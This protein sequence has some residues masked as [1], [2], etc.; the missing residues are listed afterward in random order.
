MLNAVKFRE[1]WSESNELDYRGRVRYSDQRWRVRRSK[2]VTS[3]EAIVESRDELVRAICVGHGNCAQ[4]CR[5]SRVQAPVRVLDRNAIGGAKS[6]AGRREQCH[7]AQIRLGSRLADRG[8]FGRD[9]GRE[10]GTQTFALQQ[11]PDLVPARARCDRDRHGGG[12]PADRVG[13][14]G[15]ED[16]DV[17]LEAHRSRSALRATR[18]M[19]WAS[20]QRH[21]V[22][23]SNRLE[24]PHIVETEVVRV[25]VGLGEG[26]RP[27]SASTSR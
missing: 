26:E 15:K 27:S 16:R 25:V 2:S 3:S 17:A 4:P 1:E 22:P 19:I 8:V 23:L 12:R 11:A 9:D 13:G 18:F 20:L 6:T 10:A 14:A 21:A 5:A 24:R 7:R